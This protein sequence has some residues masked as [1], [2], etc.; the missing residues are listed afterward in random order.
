MSGN[1]RNNITEMPYAKWLEQT[2]HDISSLPVKGIALLVST[3]NG[4]SY[5]NYYNVSMADKLIMAGRSQQ[6]STLDMLA[7]NGIIQYEDDEEDDDSEEEN[8]GEEE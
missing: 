5:T 8:N 3:E 6:D 1:N 4:D 7:A 2:L